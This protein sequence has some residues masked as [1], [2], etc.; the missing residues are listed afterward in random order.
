M[1]LERK[2][3]V[4]FM[5]T[6]FCCTL[7]FSWEYNDDFE[8]RLKC[9]YNHIYERITS[10]FIFLYNTI[11]LLKQVISYNCCKSVCTFE[12]ISLYVIVLFLYYPLH[13]H[14]MWYMYLHCI[15]IRFFLIAHVRTCHEF[16]NIFSRD[17]VCRSITHE[18]KNEPYFLSRFILDENLNRLMPD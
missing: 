9:L 17:L 4:S 12:N 1:G 15:K 3:K 6:T 5:T 18:R 8:V 16:Y 11:L 2:R 14:L 7:N 13:L 10:R